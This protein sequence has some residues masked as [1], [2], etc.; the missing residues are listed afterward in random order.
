MSTLFEESAEAEYSLQGALLKKKKRLGC[1]HQKGHRLKK[2]IIFTILP[3]VIFSQSL[4]AAKRIEVSPAERA[5]ILQRAQVWS[6]EDGPIGAKNLLQGPS[7]KYVFNQQINCKFFDSFYTEVVGSGKT[8][9]F[10]CVPQGGNPEQDEIKVKYNQENGEVF[11]E[12]A[13]SR[14]IWALGFFAD[15]ALPISVSCENCPES[16]WKY[17][18]YMAVYFDLPA[19]IRPPGDDK[20][21][22]ASV[23]LEREQKKRTELNE[24][25]LAN[26]GLP[27]RKDFSVALSESKYKGKG[28][29]VP[30]DPKSGVGL[31]EMGFISEAK[32]GATRAQVDALR[33]LV[34]FIKHGDNKNENQR[35][36]CPDKEILQLADG[37]ESCRKPHIVIQDAGATFGNGV[38]NIIGVDIGPGKN[39]KMSYAGWRDTP[40]WKDEANCVA[41]LG[42]NLRNGTMDDPVIT[43]A[44]R[45]FLADLLVQLTDRQ[46]TDLFRAARVDQ[47]RGI[48][49]ATVEQWVAL[50]KDKRDQITKRAPC[51]N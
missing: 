49:S 11:A 41:A 35:L 26:T 42:D 32:G 40:V 2:S 46:I 24:T 12:V 7:N 9:K 37:R 10:W 18:N 38:I 4:F 39:S 15:R 13:S 22:E 29:S 31:D 45:K 1:A 28:I 6:N 5:E 50:F 30:Q 3:F 20:K 25:S 34:A 19:S 48:E 47:R 43:E 23:Y 51:P 14:L 44:G 21:Y 8:E 36:V 33:L 27:Y 16:P 17:L